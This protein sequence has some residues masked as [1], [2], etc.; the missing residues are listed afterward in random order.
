MDCGVWVLVLLLQFPW[1]RNIL[2]TRLSCLKL[3]SHLPQHQQQDL[4]PPPQP[5]V[6]IHGFMNAESW[7]LTTLDKWSVGKMNVAV[8][9]TESAN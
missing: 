6:E 5:V 7:L 1:S 2:L 4:T 8:T 9:Y 3:I